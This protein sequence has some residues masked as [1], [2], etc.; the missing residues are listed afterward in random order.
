MKKH[1]QKLGLLALLAFAATFVP[2]AHAALLVSESF[3]YSGARVSGQNGGT[4]WGSVWSG[5]SGAANGSTVSSLTI[6]NGAFQST[7][8]GNNLGP[9][10][11]TSALTSE[12]NPTF[13]FSVNVTPVAYEALNQ[14][15]EDLLQFSVGP[16]QPVLFSVGVRASSDGVFRVIASGN[17]RFINIG[18][19][20]TTTPALNVTYSIVGKF[21]FATGTLEIWTNPI[22][23]ESSST[24]AG[25][26]TGISGTSISRV[27]L[28]RIGK[29]DIG[30]NN[31]TQFDDI[32]IGTDWAS[33]TGINVP[34]PATTTLLIGAFVIGAGF[35][36]RQLRQR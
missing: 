27:L 21:S 24:L 23:S 25:T 36:A 10:S 13:Y 35:A 3:D 17:N 32:K 12:T 8:N 22:G 5:G 19:T 9:R 11:F 4:G 14:Q 2:A 30:A 16:S 29:T 28:G 15:V 26:I 34:E 7:G 20:G 1:S 33:V 31:I 6:V 18:P